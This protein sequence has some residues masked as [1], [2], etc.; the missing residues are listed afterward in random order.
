MSYY[1]NPHTGSVDTLDGWYPSTPAKDELVKVEKNFTGFTPQ[2]KERALSE[3]VRLS[4]YERDDLQV[5]EVIKEIFDRVS[6]AAPGDDMS[7]E[8]PS[9]HSASGHPEHIDVYETDLEFEWIEVQ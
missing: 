4:K 7:Y 3:Y 2:G 9:A 6:D 1:M 5:D 8:I